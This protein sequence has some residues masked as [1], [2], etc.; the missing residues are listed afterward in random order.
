[1]ITFKP[2]THQFFSGDRE[3]PGVTSIIRAAGLMGTWQVDPWYMKRGEYVHTATALLDEGKLDFDTLDAEVRPFVECYKKFLE[4]SKCDILESELVVSD[5]TES[6]AGI[7][8]RVVQFPDGSR[9]ALDLKCGSKQAWHWLQ[10]AAYAECL[11]LSM[12]LA[13]L[14]LNN[15]GNM[16]RLYIHPD[17]KQARA[18]WLAVLSTHLKGDSE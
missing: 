1:M 7:I 14:C 17:P 18:W 2:D 13:I 4:T 15:K 8:D 11:S 5:S 16:P 10:V 12:D 6:Y 9:A 3:V